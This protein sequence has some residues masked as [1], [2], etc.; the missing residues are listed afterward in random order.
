VQ[1]LI[2]R[3]EEADRTYREAAERGLDAQVGAMETRA[4]VS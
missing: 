3:Q 4:G 2:R 1:Q